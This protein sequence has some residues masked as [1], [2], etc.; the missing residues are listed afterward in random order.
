MD[1][2]Q[3]REDY[4]E[5]ILQLSSTGIAP[6]S[7]DI[8]KHLS[9]SKP[10]VSIAMKKLLEDN[11]IYFDNENRIHLT[12]EGKTIATKTLEKHEFLKSFF[13][14]AGI[15]EKKSESIACNIEH[16]IDEESFLKLKSYLKK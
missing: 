3:S 6:K 11:L 12:S 1:K 4:L 10:S 2:R 16:N 8:A 14:K 15:D 7:I 9:F 13:L 5:A